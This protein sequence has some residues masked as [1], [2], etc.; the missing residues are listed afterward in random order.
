[1]LGSFRIKILINP[2]EGCIPRTVM[3]RV[4]G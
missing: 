1:M 2:N 3:L 4:T